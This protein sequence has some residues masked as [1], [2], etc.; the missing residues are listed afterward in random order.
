MKM[1]AALK[2]TPNVSHVFHS[3]GKRMGVSYGSIWNIA[4]AER[5][6][7]VRYSRQWGKPFLS[8]KA[9]QRIVAALKEN[10]NALQVARKLR[11]KYDTVWRVAQEEG[12][13]LSQGRAAYVKK[14]AKITE[15]LKCNPN[16]PQVAR[17]LGVHNDAVYRVA[18]RARKNLAENG[19]G[20]G[21]ADPPR[22]SR[23]SRTR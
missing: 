14:C 20:A 16:M 15:A 11:V 9:R 18:R 12:I 2:A 4:A 8:Q 19:Q 6:E 3:V 13:E 23:L 21:G 22:T 7:L 1:A 10:P 17:E 5:I